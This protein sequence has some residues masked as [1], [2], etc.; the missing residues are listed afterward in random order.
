MHGLAFPEPGAGIVRSVE[1][2]GDL[3]HVA[4]GGEI[5]VST[6]QDLRRAL[7]HCL[8][9]GCKQITIDAAEVTFIDSTGL[10]AL[11]L[12][13]SAVHPVGSVTV[14]NPS[15][16]LRRMLEITGLSPLLGTPPPAPGGS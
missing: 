8:D 14:V 2:Q 13:H 4:I 9:A 16:M 3:C 6:V 11:A 5:D 7:A 15:R 1:A 12:T 10:A